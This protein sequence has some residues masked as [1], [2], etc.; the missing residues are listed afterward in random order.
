MAAKFIGT[1][2]IHLIE[3][4]P[5]FYWTGEIIDLGNQKEY[6]GKL[7]REIEQLFPGLREIKISFS[8]R[9]NRRY[10]V[11]EAFFID[12]RLNGARFTVTRLK[13][14]H[15]DNLLHKLFALKNAVICIPGL[16]P[17]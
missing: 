15:Q 9:K 1:F 7:I 16:L 13:N 8:I 17:D 3:A 11:G 5:K 10:L 2:F 4:E 6:I 14:S 12:Y